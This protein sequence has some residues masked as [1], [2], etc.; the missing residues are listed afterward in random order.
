MNISFQMMIMIKILVAN[1]VNDWKTKMKGDNRGRISLGLAAVL[2]LM[3][4]ARLFFLLDTPNSILEF[5]DMVT[6]INV[7]MLADIN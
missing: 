6:G 7:V 4:T 5:D 3:K 2:A 1:L